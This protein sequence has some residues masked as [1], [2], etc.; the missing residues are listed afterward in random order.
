MELR[1]NSLTD[2]THAVLIPGEIAA[3]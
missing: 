2:E 3:M 1:V